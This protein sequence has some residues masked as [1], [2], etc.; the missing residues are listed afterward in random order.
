MAPPR[1]VNRA[2]T[3]PTTAAARIASTT[4]THVGVLLV[5]LALDVVV[6]GDVVGGTV[7]VV[8]TVVPGAVVV[9]WTVVVAV[10][11]VVSVP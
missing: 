4:H 9:S 7:A 6:V 10:S 5:E 2:T 11:V 3:R 8:T 1:R